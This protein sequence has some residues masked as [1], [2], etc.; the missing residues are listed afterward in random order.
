MHDHD[1]HAMDYHYD[2]VY[3]YAY[4]ATGACGYMD[5]H[6]HVYKHTHDN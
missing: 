5:R 6:D 4:K 1:V 2:Y 3:G